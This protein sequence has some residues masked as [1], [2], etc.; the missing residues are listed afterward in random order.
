MELGESRDC[1]RKAANELISRNA[2]NEHLLS[3]L[4]DF[5]QKTTTYEQKEKAVD[6]LQK[7]SR[8]RLEEANMEKDRILL[9]E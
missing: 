4:E 3:L 9:K 2:E 5:E 1:H 6:A 7:E 8:Q